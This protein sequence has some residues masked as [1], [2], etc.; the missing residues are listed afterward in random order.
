M[1]VKKVNSFDV[2]RL[3]G[4]SQPTVSRALRNLP[5]TSSQTRE[6]VLRAAAELSYIPSD[7][8]RSLSTQSTRRIAVVSED[9]TNPYYPELVEP[10]RRRLA[11]HGLRTVVVSDSVQRA[12]GL[13]VLA[14]GSYDAVVL[15]TCERRSSLPRDLTERGI[16]HVLVNRVL[17]VAESHSCSVDNRGGTAAVAGL[18]A[19]MGHR[20]V[21]AVLGPVATSTGRER[22][23]ALRDGLRARG[24]HL[25]RDMV[26]RTSFGHDPGR[27]AAHELLSREDRPTAIVCGNDVIALGVLSAARQLGIAVPEQ[28]TVVGFDDIP[29]AGWAIAD[30]TTVRCDLEALAAAAVDLLLTELASPGL[31]P[32]EQRIPVTLVLRGTHG[33]APL[34]P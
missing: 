17:D 20:R 33:P 29:M 10:L 3:A 34:G 6:K 23:E 25:R 1:D 30:L 32:V 9:L 19:D 21:G 24:V 28:L 11:D 13:D 12:V 26:R 27:D 5:G 22:A 14:D 15:T 4:V 31:P 16:P 2:A 8:G 18:V 7:S